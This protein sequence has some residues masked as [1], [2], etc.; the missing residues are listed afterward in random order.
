MTP[1]RQIRLMSSV[2]A[3]KRS[4]GNRARSDSTDD[5]TDSGNSGPVKVAAR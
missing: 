5:R 2:K 1:A 4:E 3:Q